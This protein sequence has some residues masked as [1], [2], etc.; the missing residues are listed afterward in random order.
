ME[1]DLIYSR[2][3][4]LFDDPSFFKLSEEDA[5]E[6]LAI[7]L[8]GAANYPYVKKIF[9]TLIL[10]NE[11]MQLTFELKSSIDETSDEAFVIEVL[12]QGMVINWMKKQIDNRINT[13][14]IIGTKEEKRIQSNYK[15]NMDRLN[16][17][18]REHKNLVCSYGYYNGI[19]GRE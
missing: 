9:S 7:W 14:S 17:L 11:I 18:I 19:S 16:Q 13:A 15:T 8:Q 1:Y 4:E 10:D 3:F 2:F 12:A 5:N 6:M